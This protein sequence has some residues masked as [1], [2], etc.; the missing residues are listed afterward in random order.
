MTDSESKTPFATDQQRE[1]VS[2]SGHSAHQ[3]LF[4]PITSSPLA[5]DQFEFDIPVSQPALQYMAAPGSRGTVHPGT[6]GA[7]QWVMPKFAATGH[8]STVSD[9]STGGGLDGLGQPSQQVM[10]SFT[11]GLQNQ[12]PRQMAPMPPPYRKPDVSCPVPSQHH[13]ER[14]NNTIQGIEK[15]GPRGQAAMPPGI[16]TPYDQE[17]LAHQ[18]KPRRESVR[19]SSSQPINTPHHGSASRTTSATQELQRPDNGFS[20]LKLMQAAL[21]QRTAFGTNTKKSETQPTSTPRHDNVSRSQNEMSLQQ[22]GSARAV[23]LAQ[24]QQRAAGPLDLLA[25]ENHH[26]I[27][28]PIPSPNDLENALAH[29]S[30]TLHGLDQRGK[31]LKQRLLSISLPH[32]R[33]IDRKMVNAGLEALH[34]FIEGEKR[35]T[36]RWRDVLEIMKSRVG[37]PERRKWVESQL[38]EAEKHFEGRMSQLENIR[39]ALQVSA[40]CVLR[41]EQMQEDYRV[42]G[43]YRGVAGR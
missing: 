15:S 13:P 42:F 25:A 28:G 8:S 40:H 29:W 17:M 23:L 2:A 12:A 37:T 30:K 4:Y 7:Q 31:L 14:T 6:M 18:I 21:A 33:E 41:L 3:N 22:Y 24:Y 10:D 34:P 35:K 11:L 16:L 20:G 39:S 9:S 19:M 36:A 27:P 32:H 1:Q 26:A 43:R 5:M 38:K